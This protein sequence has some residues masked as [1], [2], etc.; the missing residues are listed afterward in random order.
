MGRGVCVCVGG[1]GGLGGKI[2]EMGL[3][4][5]KKRGAGWSERAVRRMGEERKNLVLP[6]RVRTWAWKWARKARMVCLVGSGTP[7][8]RGWSPSTRAYHSAL[9]ASSES[10]GSRYPSKSR[11]ARPSASDSQARRKQRERMSPTAGP[12]R[13]R[14]ISAVLPPSSETG[15]TWATRE[16]REERDAATELKAVP[17][18]KTVRQGSVVGAGVVV[19]GGAGD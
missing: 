7:S 3:G 9:A 19:R 14:T 17:P 1:G 13:T 5:G 18:E 4:K 8:H 2:D 10:P 12:P 16:E 15:R 6:V 11:T